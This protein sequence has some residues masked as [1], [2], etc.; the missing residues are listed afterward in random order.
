[1]IGGGAV[2]G[3]YVHG[4]LTHPDTRNQLWG[5]IPQELQAVYGVTMWLAA[6][7]YFFFSYALVVRADAEEVRFGPFGFGLITALYAV[8]MAAAASWMPLTFAYF[9]DPSDA[10]WLTIRVGL[11]AVGAGSV[12]LTVALF[13]MK[14]RAEG[15]SGILA[16]LGLLFFCLQTAFLDAFVWPQ[17]F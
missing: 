1:V 15:I 14:P 4:L 12:G 5:S 11:F 7:G 3:S 17:F 16:L 13:T 10:L 9:D 8:I 6:A 2:L